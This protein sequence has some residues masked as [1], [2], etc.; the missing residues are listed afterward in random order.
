MTTVTN[1]AESEL[2]VGARLEASLPA[3]CGGDTVLPNQY[4][5]IVGRRV[6]WMASTGWRSRCWPTRS[7]A[8]TN[9]AMQ[10]AARGGCSLRK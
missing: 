1:R 2:E 10:E 9:I 4:Y 5:D 3:N 7:Q 6:G 8:T